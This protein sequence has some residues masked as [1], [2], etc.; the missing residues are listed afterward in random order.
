MSLE[1]LNYYRLVHGLDS[2]S[3]LPKQKNINT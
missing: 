2:L 1:E 3:E